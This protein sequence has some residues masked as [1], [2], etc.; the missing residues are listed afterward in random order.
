MP[1]TYTLTAGKSVTLDATGAG[2]ITLGPDSNAGP[3]NW[4]IT[5]VIVQTDRPGQAPIPRV[6][7][8]RDTIDPTNSLGLSH[9]GSF[10]QATADELIT[11]GQSLIC[12]WT[13]GQSGD[14]ATLTLSG[15]KW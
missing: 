10:G 12:V 1:E 6:Q 3:A 11:R 14:T 2:T 13:G 5:G 8:Y 4:R 9:D 7:F 15:E